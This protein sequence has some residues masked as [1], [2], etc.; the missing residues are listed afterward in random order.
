[1]P[2]A[3]QKITPCLWFDTEA[4]D[5]AKFYCSIFENSKIEQ[6]SRYV[7]AGQEIHGKKA[8]SVMVV[9]FNLEGQKFVALNGGPQ[10]K[11]DEAVSFQISCRTQKEVDYFWSKLTAEG[12]KEGPCGWLKDKFGLSWQVVPTSLIDMM[13]DKDASKVARVTNA[14]LKMKKFDIEA[15][16]RAFD[17]KH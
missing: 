1:M 7:D 10:F 4:E 13:L 12:G 2:I 6:V 9:A 11:F 15:L 8:G 3:E 5:A 14:F 17:G 16:K